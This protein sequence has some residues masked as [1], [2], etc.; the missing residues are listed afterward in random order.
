MGFVLVYLRPSRGFL[1]LVVAKLGG[2]EEE[3]EEEEEEA[4]LVGEQGPG[5]QQQVTIYATAIRIGKESS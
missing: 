3:E 1:A 5:R 4:A 2:A